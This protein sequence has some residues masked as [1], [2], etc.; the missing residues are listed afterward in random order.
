MER[1]KHTARRS[2]CVCVS[3]SSYA[4]SLPMPF[5]SFLTSRR[6][7]VCVCISCNVWTVSVHQPATSFA[8]VDGFAFFEALDF[9]PFRNIVLLEAFILV[10][11]FSLDIKVFEHFIPCHRYGIN[12]LNDSFSLTSTLTYV[13]KMLKYT[14]IHNIYILLRLN[15]SSG[16]ESETSE[17]SKFPK[18]NSL[19]DASTNAF[20]S[21]YVWF[22]F[23]LSIVNIT[24]HNRQFINGLTLY[25]VGIC[26]GMVACEERPEDAG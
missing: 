2:F 20:G 17:I 16:V 25:R 21:D 6:M 4:V 23:G 24:D 12:S 15:L 26:I 11:D 13:W 8:E 19:N 18:L 3:V 7:A 10:V 1:E 9:L 22:D 14:S 5:E